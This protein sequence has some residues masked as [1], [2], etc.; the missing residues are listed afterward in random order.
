MMGKPMPSTRKLMQ[1]HWRNCQK[2]SNSW[3]TLL[4]KATKS[5]KNHWKSRYM[6]NGATK[7]SINLAHRLILIG[8][9]NLRDEKQ[10]KRDS[11]KSKSK[12]CLV[13]F[14]CKDHDHL[15][16]IPN[17]HIHKK[18]SS[19]QSINHSHCFSKIENKN[20]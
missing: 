15:V 11:V 18:Y 16:D 6:I 2:V 8:I 4:P 5:K 19:N 17:D 20:H 1:N 9:K 3:M 13:I 7:P 12:L 10:W 14:K